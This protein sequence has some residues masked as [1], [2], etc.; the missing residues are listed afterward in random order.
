M[1][2][3]DYHK[4][5][6]FLVADANTRVTDQA[7]DYGKGDRESE[8]GAEIERM[9]GEGGDREKEKKAEEAKADKGDSKH[10]HSQK[11]AT[12]GQKHMH[13]QRQRQRQ[14][15]HKSRQLHM[16]HGSRHPGQALLTVSNHAACVDDFV[17]LGSL[18]PVQNIFRPDLMR[19]DSCVFTQRHQKKQH[20]RMG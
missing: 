3:H 12:K 20:G 15:K 4:L 1:H 7:V 13:T 19:Y 6:R 8:L 18:I 16:L 17:V 9:K 11:D 5:K 2:I 14:Q 10:R